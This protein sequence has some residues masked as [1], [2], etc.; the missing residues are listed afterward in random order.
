M[1]TQT[2]ENAMG[3]K[4]TSK[5]EGPIYTTVKIERAVHARLKIVSG[6]TGRDISEMVSEILKA[7]VDRLYKDAVA[8]LSEPEKPK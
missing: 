3:R 5:S 1:L 6:I 7:P 2:P 4:K 8:K